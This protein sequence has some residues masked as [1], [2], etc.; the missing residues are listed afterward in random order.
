M[1]SSLQDVSK[2]AG[3]PGAK[4]QIS[5]ARPVYGS[6]LKLASRGQAALTR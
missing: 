4:V 1:A 3:K 6:P 5:R 2:D